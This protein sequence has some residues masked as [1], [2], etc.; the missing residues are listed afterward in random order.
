MTRSLSPCTTGF[1]AEGWDDHSPGLNP[2]C[3][4]TGGERW[5]LALKR[6]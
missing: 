2:I 1:I 5:V 6:G 4:I 3:G